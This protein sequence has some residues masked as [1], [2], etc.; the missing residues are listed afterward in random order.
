MH[1][2]LSGLLMDSAIVAGFGF[3]TYGFILLGIGK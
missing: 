3:A 1:K 2:Y